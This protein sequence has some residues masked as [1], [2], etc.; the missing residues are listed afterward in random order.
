MSNIALSD[1]AVAQIRAFN[2]MYTQQMGVLA[3]YLDGDLSL[4]QARL[5][6][7]L[8]Q[9]TPSSSALT[10][11][12][13]CE[14]LGLDAGY[15]SRELR[16][17]E[18]KGWLSKQA[19]AQDAR[20]QSLSLTAA[21]KK[22]FAPLQR[23]SQEQAAQ[24]LQRLSASQRKRLL[25]AMKD[26]Q[27]CLVAK[28][29]KSVQQMQTA[30]LRDPKPGDMGWVIEQHGE[31]YAREYGWNWEFEALVAGICADFIKNFQPDWERCWMAELDGERV[32][33]IFVVR[34]NASTAQLRML[35]LTPQA[36][37]LGLGARLTD[38]AISFARERGYKKMVLW[39]NACLL[40]ARA[41][42]E[43]RGFKLTQSEAYEGFGHP[44][45]SETWALKL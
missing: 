7:E 25:S 39:T 32:G 34:K 15:V 9:H 28:P 20:S 22:A 10:A 29:E 13:L 11:K 33:S 1:P 17:F 36:R 21:G 18:A 35:I 43:K 23:H 42:Y 12:L 16:K 45:V 38:E 4:T 30:I 14:R 37:G 31:I 6:Y 26:M 5:L 2:R 24:L 40:T 41:I 44:Q 8:A 19:H 3:P 27:S